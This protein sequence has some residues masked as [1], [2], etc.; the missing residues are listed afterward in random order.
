MLRAGESGGTKERYFLDKEMR[1]RDSCRRKHLA[2][3]PLSQGRGVSKAR[4]PGQASLE[5]PRK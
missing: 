2:G 1:V 4:L 3:A 5:A